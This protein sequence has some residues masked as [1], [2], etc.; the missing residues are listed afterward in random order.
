MAC[1]PLAIE[2][3]ATV[4]VT[5]APKPFTEKD[6]STGSL[7]RPPEADASL[8]ASLSPTSL[9]RSST[10]S[11]VAAETTATGEPAS[12]VDSIN[13]SIW[14][15]TSSS[16]SGPARSALVMAKTPLVTPRRFTMSRCSRVWG[17][18]PSSAATTKRT[19]SM[20]VIPASMFLMKRSC[21]GTSTMAALT[22]R[23]PGRGPGKSQ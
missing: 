10:P 4:P 14:P 7:N 8:G 3:E 16:L 5:T 19:M 6:L 9:L 15:R 20:P 22:G 23:P 13:P 12:A 1:S 17:I 11:P 21:P 18:T 2:P